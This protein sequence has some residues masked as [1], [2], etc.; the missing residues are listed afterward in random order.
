[1]YLW[2]DEFVSPKKVP[3]PSGT[4]LVCVVCKNIP[5]AS[6]R[7][8]NLP[9][10]SGTFLVCKNIPEASGRFRNILSGALGS[11]IYG[12]MSLFP[13]RRF[14]N[15]PE[16]SGMFIAFHTIHSNVY[17]KAHTAHFPHEHAFHTFHIKTYI[18]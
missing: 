1:M 9:E 5:E 16:G 7:F 13:Q 3:E 6:G 11:C 10:P 8:R 2:N 14:R 4:F 15:L 17:P 18:L 12:M